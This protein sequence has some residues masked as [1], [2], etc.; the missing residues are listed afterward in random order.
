MKKA[1]AFAT[2]LIVV[3]VFSVG[4]YAAT[5]KIPGLVVTYRKNI[6]KTTSTLRF[7]A[8]PDGIAGKY[9]YR[10]AALVLDKNG[11]IVKSAGKSGGQLIGIN[12]GSEDKVYTVSVN[13]SSGT[14]GQGAAMVISTNGTYS[15]LLTT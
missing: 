11:N 15:K 2:V 5:F 9:S 10:M 14:K 6:H 8:Q 7:Y 12:Y 3:L 4:T 1:I 13:A